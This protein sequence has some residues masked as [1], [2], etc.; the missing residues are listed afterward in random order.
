MLNISLCGILG[1]DKN[2]TIPLRGLR[3]SLNKDNI[4]CA[5]RRYS[6]GISIKYDNQRDCLNR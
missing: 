3:E 1:K 5:L 4:N 6:I 2:L